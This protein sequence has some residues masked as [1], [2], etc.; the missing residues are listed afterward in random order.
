MSHGSSRLLLLLTYGQTL[1]VSNWYVFKECLTYQSI[2]Y[3]QQLDAIILDPYHS[4]LASICLSL[5]ND[6]RPWRHDAN[7]PAPFD[8]NT[9]MYDHIH[10]GRLHWCGSSKQHIITYSLSIDNFMG[11][12]SISS[13]PPPIKERC[14][15]LLVKHLK[16]VNETACR[17]RCV[18]RINTYVTRACFF[19]KIYT[20]HSLCRKDEAELMG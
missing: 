19:Q 17:W 2:S 14:Y 1:K 7:G 11:T 9:A 12:S 4:V 6:V 5:L 13:S 8:V 16:E 10:E 20:W 15:T 3:M 18:A